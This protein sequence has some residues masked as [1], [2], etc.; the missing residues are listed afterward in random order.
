MRRRFS[1]LMTAGLLCCYSTIAGAD[2][3]M[4]TDE[5]GIKHIT[6]TIPPAGAEILMQTEE[7]P[8]DEA[9]DKERKASEQLEK[10]IA[11]RQEILDLEA[12]LLEMQRD[13]NRRVETANQKARDALEYAEYWKR[14]AQENYYGYSG[15]R[16]R[17]VRPYPYVHH[18]K[19]YH[20]NRW[21]Y[22]YKGNIYNKPSYY[23]H[24]KGHTKKHHLKKRSHTYGA[25]RRHTIHRDRSQGRYKKYGHHQA[26]SYGSRSRGA[27]ARKYK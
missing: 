18:Y 13:A 16:I 20:S 14:A 19:K 5:N 17:Y 9:A 4:W 8:Y 2:I 25:K 22:H 1:F 23:D 12:R 11:T 27:G 21:Y 26:K 10:A 7:I 6:N 24:R 3:Y 15:T